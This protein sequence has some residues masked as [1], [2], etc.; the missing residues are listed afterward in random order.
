MSKQNT[1]TDV[2]FISALAELLNKNELTE[3]SVKRE[4][5][6]DDSLEV[7]VVKQATVVT[8]AAAPAPVLHH[9]APAAAPAAVAA[10][11]APEDPAQHP[12]AVTS[13]MVGT[14]Y[15]AAEPG[16]SPFVT[17]GAQV[18]EGQTVLIIEAMKTMNHIPAPRAGIVKRILVEDGH[19]VEYGAP[20]MIVE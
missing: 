12:G 10:P 3:L 19:P 14:V 15:L 8:V 9:A 6:E 7:R 1:D 4:Y 5:G 13:P 2:A 18:S 17:V 16:A 20:L 11:A